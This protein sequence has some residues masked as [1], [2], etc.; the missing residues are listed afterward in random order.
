MIEELFAI[1]KSP[2][3]RIEPMIRIVC[4][5][6]LSIAAALAHHISIMPGYILVSVALTIIAQLNPR[7]VLKRIKPVFIFLVMIW[8]IV[9]ITFEGQVAFR[10]GFIKISQPGIHLCS[11]IT[12]KSISI[13][14]IFTALIATMPI[15]SLGAGLHRLYIPDKL[16]F[17]LLMS[18]RYIAVIENE[19]KKLLRAAKFRGFVPGTN[20]HSYKT[21][22]YLAG[23]LFV[24]ASLRAQR[25]YHAMVC[26]GF[27]GKFHTLDI[28]PANR[29]NFP[30]LII[31]LTMGLCFVW[32]DFY[33]MD[34]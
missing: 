14:L 3:H 4:A 9:P 7:D 13:L 5:A 1:G 12:F 20:L 2:I 19:Y 10:I 17:L 24:R 27:D 28:Y 21:Y 8:I 22:A 15:A 18:Y 32:L 26:R 30:F 34:T 6:V 31:T 11:M 25:V 33:W 23:M 16:V 29:L